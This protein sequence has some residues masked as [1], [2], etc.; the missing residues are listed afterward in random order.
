[1]NL[2]YTEGRYMFI[3]NLIKKHKLL[4]EICLYIRGC[5]VVKKNQQNQKKILTFTKQE[6][7]T[8]DAEMYKKR[9]GKDLDWNNL[10]TY[11]EKM[12][13]AK[14]FDR[15]PIKSKL[16]DKYLVREWVT[17]KIG[18]E[19][20]VPLIGVWDKYSDIDFSKLPEKFVIKT[21]HG[22]SDVVIVKNKSTM[23]LYEKIRMKRIISTSMS[24]NYADYAFE[25]HY[26]EIEPK[27]IVE[28]YIESDNEDLRDYKFL[29][30]DGIPYYCWVD[31]GRN[32]NHKR[33]VYDMD[34]N[35]Q[36]W[37]Q[38]HY[39]N[40]EESIDKPDNFEK[41]IEIAQKLSEGF[42]HVRVDL[43]NNNGKIFFGEMT[44]TNGSG[45][46][47]ITPKEMDVHLGKLWKLDMTNTKE[48][49]G[50]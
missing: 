34:W 16:A 28:K 19:Y 43:Y 5:I 20:L 50:N 22:S 49:W 25:L 24:T 11:T 17:T 32:T 23:K 8:M 18:S 2:N 31:V 1:M 13:W 6:L 37:N 14:I 30:F 45:F 15:N 40:A 36:E 48:C 9:Q 38:F 12:Q 10:Q 42:P 33:N 47:E 7:M 41:M 21:N 46:E 4:Y 3:K 27:I 39:G 26:A 44:F 35:L 29:C